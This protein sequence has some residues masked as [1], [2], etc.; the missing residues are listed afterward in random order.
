[1]KNKI[2]I[3]DIP[4]LEVVDLLPIVERFMYNNVVS[5]K[6]I[7]VILK[8]ISFEIQKTDNGA[9]SCSFVYYFSIIVIIL[10]N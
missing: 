8:R 7:N 6:I 10:I 3:F 4:A 2:D 9:I 5:H 1:M